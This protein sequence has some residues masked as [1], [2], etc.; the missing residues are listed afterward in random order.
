MEKYELHYEYY[1]EPTWN[2]I[3][4]N[5]LTGNYQKEYTEWLEDQLLSISRDESEYDDIMMTHRDMIIDSLENY[6][7]YFEDRLFSGKDVNQSKKNIEQID[8][9]IKLFTTYGAF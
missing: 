2:G 9:I 6:K 7:E 3:H 8:K 1:K 5:P 4:I